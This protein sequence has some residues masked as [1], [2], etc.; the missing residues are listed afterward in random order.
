LTTLYTGLADHQNVRPT[1]KPFLPQGCVH[2]K[3]TIMRNKD[4]GKSKSIEGAVKDKARELI[5]DPDL[6]A[7]GETERLN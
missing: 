6:E 2:L 1:L 3:E 4:D 5:N 7:K